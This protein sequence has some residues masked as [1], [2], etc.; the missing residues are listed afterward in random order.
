M[1]I[2]PIRYKA[3]V[4]YASPSYYRKLLRLLKEYDIVSILDETFTSGW[5]T[6]RLFTYYSCCSELHP[7][8]VV[9]GGRMQINGVFYKRSLIDSL[10]EL[11]A[12]ANIEININSS[13]DLLQ[14]Q[15]FSLLKKIVYDVDWLDLHTNN[16]SSSIRTEFNEIQ[17]KA[18]VQ[19]SN[20]RGKGKI[21]AFDVAHS[22]L[23]DEIVCS[24]LRKGIRLGY[25]GDKTIV[26]TPS[27]LFTE[28]HFTPIKEFLISVVPSTYHMSKI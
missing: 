22:I 2:E 12:K 17:Q 25:L 18:F 9:F 21:I 26:L 19:Y 6:G 23:R 13:I 16:F 8:A 28:I 5:A 10:E 27:L 1:I 4:Q 20:V 24:A 3:G 7:D 14:F 15:K 11:Q